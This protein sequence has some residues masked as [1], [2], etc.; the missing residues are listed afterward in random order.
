MTTTSR[1]YIVLTGL[2]LFISLTAS[3]HAGSYDRLLQKTVS[4]KATCVT[5]I[6]TQLVLSVLFLI[7]FRKCRTNNPARHLATKISGKPA[8]ACGAFWILSAFTL[9]PYLEYFDIMQIIA[10]GLS[11]PNLVLIL[12]GKIRRCLISEKSL[13]VCIHVAASQV[14]GYIVYLAVFQTDWFGMIFRYTDD[15]YQIANYYLYPGIEGVD[16]CII[17]T[18]TLLASLSIPYIVLGVVRLVRQII[19]RVKGRKHKGEMNEHK[20]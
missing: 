18:F 1:K 11:L 12:I 4:I 5:V 14:I 3:A 13:Y 19:I 20:E 16:Y 17:Y 9:T 15:L 7:I 8:L 6:I 2:L 10:I